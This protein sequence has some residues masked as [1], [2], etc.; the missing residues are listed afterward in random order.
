[1]KVKW[2]QTVARIVPFATMVA[3]VVL[4]IGSHA[5]NVKWG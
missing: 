4:T 5:D 1:M 3:A 2:K